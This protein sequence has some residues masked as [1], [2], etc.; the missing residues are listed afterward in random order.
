MKIYLAGKID[1]E[2]GSWRD[3]LLEPDY[4]SWPHMPRWQI[5]YP[6]AQ[7]ERGYSVE[8]PPAWPR[9]PN[10]WV[11]GLLDYVGPYRV[12]VV[13]SP[14]SKSSGEFHGSTWSGQHGCM[15][16]AFK[17]H[18]VGSCLTAIKR[19]DLVFA[20]INT[21]D[22]HGTLVEVGYAAALGKFIYVVEGTEVPYEDYWFGA[23]LATCWEWLHDG[24]GQ[25][26][27][28]HVQRAV[29]QFAST[30]QLGH[31]VSPRAVPEA[32]QAFRDI[33]R[34]TSDPR[35]RNE[36]QRMLRQLSDP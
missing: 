10:R 28:Q 12:D 32:A 29:T 19:A 27:E 22:C 3:Q 13:P 4:R 30:Q 9:T 17:R 6:Y 7:W 5:R 34:W 2:H 25:S 18:I 33:A 20:Y 16:T 26:L 1:N 14:E 23:E 36:A 21:P 11:L 24:R 15:D 35:V 8:P 31:G